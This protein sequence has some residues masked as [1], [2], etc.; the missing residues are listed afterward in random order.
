[1]SKKPGTS[2]DAADKLLRGIKRKTSKHC[3]TGLR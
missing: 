1:M 3:S 2:E